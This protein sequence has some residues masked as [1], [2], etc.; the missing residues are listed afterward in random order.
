MLQDEVVAEEN[1]VV[2]M[3][4]ELVELILIDQPCEHHHHHHHQHHYHHHQQ[5][6]SNAINTTSWDNDTKANNKSTN[7]KIHVHVNTCNNIKESN[8]A[9]NANNNYNTNNEFDGQPVKS[10]AN[11]NITCDPRASHPQP[12]V[13]DHM[14]D[15][16]NENLL[17]VN[18]DNAKNN[19]NGLASNNCKSSSDFNLNTNAAP[20]EATDASDIHGPL[21]Y[22]HLKKP[23]I[24]SYPQYC[25]YQC[26][27]KRLT[28]ISRQ[29]DL[30]MLAYLVGKSFVQSLPSVVS[31]VDVFFCMD[32]AANPDFKSFKSELNHL[33]L[34]ACANEHQF[35]HHT[36]LHF[37]PAITNPTSRHRPLQ[38]SLVATPSLSTL[39][40]IR[41]KCTTTSQLTGAY[42][43]GS[44][45]TN[46]QHLSHTVHLT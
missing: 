12:S 20:K 5:S 3:L 14:L 29:D 44:D 25:R 33:V 21:H 8:S 2:L 30:Q 4:S 28:M 1:K 34:I 9:L 7:E 16:R 41:N 35:T 42:H 24:I 40:T 37:I 19:V 15:C 45:T 43:V 22:H 46:S 39:K 18:M 13:G 36:I 31:D 6:P 27:R 23:I 32:T 38:T 11:F 10:E 17:S 26:A